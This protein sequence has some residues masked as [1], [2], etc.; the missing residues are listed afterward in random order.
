ME[1]DSD[2]KTNIYAMIEADV[3]LNRF[4]VWQSA[5]FL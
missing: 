5:A 1:S 3:P 2:T 4:L